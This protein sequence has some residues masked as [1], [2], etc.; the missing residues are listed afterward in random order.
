MPVRN[1]RKATHIIEMICMIGIVLGIIAI[2]YL[3]G[4]NKGGEDLIRDVEIM[5]YALRYMVV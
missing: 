2:F 5:C 3:I 1:H 4:Y